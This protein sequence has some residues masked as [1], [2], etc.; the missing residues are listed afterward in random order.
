MGQKDA[1]I[2]GRYTLDKFQQAWTDINGEWDSGLVVNV[3][4][5]EC[6]GHDRSE[7]PA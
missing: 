1:R 7:M 3:I 6:I 4:K 2:E 5:F